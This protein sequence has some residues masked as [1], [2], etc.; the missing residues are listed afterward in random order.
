VI[1][2]AQDLI[3]YLS[4]QGS[5]SPLVPPTRDEIF[6]K[7]SLLQGVTVKTSQYG[8]FKAFGPEINM[9]DIP[10]DRVNYYNA[11]KVKGGKVLNI[12]WAGFT[13]SEP[14]FTFPVPG[15][16]Y[17]WV[18]DLPGFME[19]LD[20]IITVGNFTG[21]LLELPGDGQTG[22]DGNPFGYQWLMDHIDP[23]LDAMVNYKP[24]DLTKW[25]IFNP[26]FDGVV[27]NW[28]AEQVLAFGQHMRKQLPNCF[29]EIEYGAGII[30]P[31]GE[32]KAQYIGPLEV[33]DGFAQETS[34][35]PESNL[36]QIFQI[37][38]RLLG[39]LY[40]RPSS[41]KP[42][43]NPYYQDPNDD[44][45][46]PFAAGSPN[47]YLSNGTPRGKYY[48]RMREFLTYG[49]VRGWV[50]EATVDYWVSYF[51]NLGWGEGVG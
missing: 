6:N 14:G 28:S 27:W 7:W 40:N 44:P 13:Y 31:F 20:E 12:G 1:P 25:T 41:D 17:R 34:Y 42:Q 8:E 45:K 4:G 26:G 46:A 24:R 38:A 49:W 43:F 50:T 47:D 11:T 32:G 36:D 35:P 19:R 3:Y 51:T 37:G 23:L 2:S 33:F 5:T 15:P 30:G 29:L 18:N 21:I 22:A 16:A 39:P 9:L 10:S 48:T